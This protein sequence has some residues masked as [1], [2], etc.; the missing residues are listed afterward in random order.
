MAQALN[1]KLEKPPK[2]K[3]QSLLK[4]KPIAIKEGFKDEEGF[5]WEGEFPSVRMDK[6]DPYEGE[7]P[8][9]FGN[10]PIPI[11]PEIPT[12]SGHGK[13]TNGQMGYNPLFTPAGTSK[14]PVKTPVVKEEPKEDCVVMED[15]SGTGERAQ[16][17]LLDAK[18]PVTPPRRSERLN[19]TNWVPTRVTKALKKALV[20]GM[21]ALPTHS[22]A[23]PTYD[24]VAHQAEALHTNLGQ[25]QPMSCSPNLDGLR[26]YH[27]ACDKWMDLNGPDPDDHH[28]GV[29]KILE[30]SNKE[31][32]DGKRSVFFKVSFQDD[33]SKAWHKMDTMR[34]GEPHLTIAYALQKGLVNE[35]GFEWVKTYLEAD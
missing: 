19:R 16:D 31:V 3:F 15:D 24:M 32:K 28:L 20:L 23:V 1:L 10:K 35:P 9:R 18:E 29:S 33:E 13:L 8:L 21:C 14:K 27:A 11:D 26:A 34:E 4:S 5:T 6:A 25:V 17:T 30:C 2:G 7:S 12:T 22:M